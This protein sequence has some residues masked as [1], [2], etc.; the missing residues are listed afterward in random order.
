MCVVFKDRDAAKHWIELEHT[1]RNEGAGVD[2]WDP[3]QKRSISWDS[4]QKEFQILDY[5]GDENR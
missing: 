2:P 5:V 3:I 1:G 4:V